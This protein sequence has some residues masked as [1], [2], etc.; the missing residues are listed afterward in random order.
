MTLSIFKKKEEEKILRWQRN[1]VSPIELK[2]QTLFIYSKIR[3]KY[4]NQ[5]VTMVY[6]KAKVVLISISHFSQ[7]VIEDCHGIEIFP[8]TDFRLQFE[9]DSTSGVIQSMVVKQDHVFDVNQLKLDVNPI[10]CYAGNRTEGN[11]MCIALLVTFHCDFRKHILGKY[12]GL[13]A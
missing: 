11:F 5:Y 7:T 3:Y 9:H 10:V 13:R 6:S 1:T 4:Y 2:R 8:E 12:Y